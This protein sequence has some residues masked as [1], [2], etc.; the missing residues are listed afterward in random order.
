M[1]FT[2][3]SDVTTGDLI[4]AATWNLYMGSSGSIDE[5]KT[6]ADTMTAISAGSQPART[7]DTV[8]QNT[9][10]KTL[11]VTVSAEMANTDDVTV[12]TD[13]STPPTT[14]VA[15]IQ[16]SGGGTLEQCVSFLVLDT[17][18]YQV[19]DAAGT[20]PIVWTEWELH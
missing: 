5:L 12:D 19:N 6:L 11:L 7:L 1:T 14:Q 2:A 15:R 16:F 17:H 4:S 10:G 8:Y 13:S 3:G 20:P 9:S 18:Y